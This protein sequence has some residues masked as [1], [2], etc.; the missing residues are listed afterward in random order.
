MQEPDLL[1]TE[2]ITAD[3]IAPFTEGRF[4]LFTTTKGIEIDAS[5]TNG[6]MKLFLDKNATSGNTT[7]KTP[8]DIANF[9][10]DRSGKN[11]LARQKNLLQ[12]NVAK[13][14]VIITTVLHLLEN[15]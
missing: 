13:A 8:T 10:K 12:I 4:F 3:A 6:S 9:F 15:S 2:V 14:F 11:D 7:S 5:C 1:P